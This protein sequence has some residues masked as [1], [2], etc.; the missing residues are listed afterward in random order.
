MSYTEEQ[1]AWLIRTGKVLVEA[2]ET[3]RQILVRDATCDMIMGPSSNFPKM[4]VEYSL[5]PTPQYR[6]YR[7]GDPV[8]WGARLDNPTDG[9]YVRLVGWNEE[10]G[11]SALVARMHN[12]DGRV[13]LDVV[14]V[15]SLLRRYTYNGKP[16]GILVTS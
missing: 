12:S 14:S 2:G 1:K 11:G 7:R 6:E 5:E 13:W 9:L 3:G 8:P 10:L 15:R 16:A 4:T